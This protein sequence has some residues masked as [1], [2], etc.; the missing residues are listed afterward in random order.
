MIE[1]VCLVG[2]VYPY[3]GGIAHFTS[4]L[5]EEFGK[6][7]DVLVVN[8]K[9]L[10]PSFLFPGKTQFDTSD[11]PLDVPSKRLI[12]TMNPLSFWSAARAMRSYQPD[13]IVFQW[14]H[15]FFAIAYAAIILLLGRSLK[16]RVAFL[17][18][19][20][21]PHERSL[22]DTVLIRLGFSQV[23]RFVQK[24][25]RLVRDKDRC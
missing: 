11:E 4:V 20:V 2:P 16:R 8:F 18:H 19:N 12:D 23:S 3:R 21:L 10:Y 22:I 25:S 1:K 6:G 17:C 9:R 24:R 13:L 15:P 5:A 7:H 14:W